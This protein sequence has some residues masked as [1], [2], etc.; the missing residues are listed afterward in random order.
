MLYVVCRARLS[1][2]GSCLCDQS[3]LTFCVN[4]LNH[5]VQKGPLCVGNLSTIS[6]AVCQETVV[7][8]DILL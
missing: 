5:M 4:C 6:G 1:G 8:H 3:F 7:K 2:D